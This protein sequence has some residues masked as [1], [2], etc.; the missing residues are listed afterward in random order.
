MAESLR[1]PTFFQPL[2]KAEQFSSK[3]HKLVLG[4]VE[5]IEAKDI[6][7]VQ[8]VSSSCCPIQ[9]QFTAKNAFLR[10]VNN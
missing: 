8:P 5:S 2:P 7:F 4:W 1:F 10:F 6:D 9:A 3:F